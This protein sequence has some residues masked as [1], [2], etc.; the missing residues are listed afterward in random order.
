MMEINTIFQG[1]ITS[2]GGFH[3][4]RGTPIAGWFIMENPT[5][6]DDDRGYPY[7]RKPPYHL[8]PIFKWCRFVGGPLLSDPDMGLENFHPA[9]AISTVKMVNSLGEKT[10]DLKGQI[11]RMCTKIGMNGR[12]ALF[13]L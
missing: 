8:S 3:S 4:H 6:M 10:A 7:F 13:R 12:H 9:V 1:I 5:R 2:C 11:C